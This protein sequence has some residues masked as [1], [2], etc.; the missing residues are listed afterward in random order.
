MVCMPAIEADAAWYVGFCV[1]TLFGSRTKV[2][3][4]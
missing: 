2:V 1:G 4:L 3:V